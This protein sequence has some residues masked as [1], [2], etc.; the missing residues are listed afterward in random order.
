MRSLF[1]SVLVLSLVPAASAQDF[2]HYK[3]DSGCT[4]EVINYATGP[5][6]L[7]ANG[8]LETTAPVS[9]WIAGR[10]GAALDGGGS[11]YYS[12]VRSGWNPGTQPLTGD[13]T[14]A[15]FMKEATATTSLN[16]LMGAPSGGFRL[17]TNGIAGR[18]LYQREIVT[19][20]SQGNRDLSLPATVT[21][22]Q[23]L[24]A[25]G[26]VH[27]AIVIDATAQT[28][29][30]YVNGTSVL[31]VTGVVGGANIVLAGPF[32]VGYY[33][34]ASYYAFDEFLISLRAYSP[35]EMMALA[36][37]PHAGD[38]AFSSGIASQCGT[39]TLA[40]NGQAP[41]IGNAGYGLV[42]NSSAT[43]AW[44]L[45]VGGSRCSIGG[46]VP[47]PFDA[48][49]LTPLAAGCWLL[50]DPAVSVGGAVASGPVQIPFAIPQDPQLGGAVLFTQGV[51]LSFAPA[52]AVEA[53][54]GLAIGLGY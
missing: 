13:L 45:N 17:F 20:S 43:G 36:L 11:G 3:F 50:A 22:V 28:A 46:L 1:S 53:T 26:W 7:G 41:T 14:I 6:A 40:G 52:N 48:G 24:A 27:I 2:I 5:Q 34:S 12:R 30:W 44:A 18:G 8:V 9:P 21:D 29:D 33:S 23:T 16:Y 4:S 42:L 19:T 35:T 31:Q 37:A 39:S 10:F 15:F 51:V 54:H 25:A 38:G 47:L 32:T 49:T